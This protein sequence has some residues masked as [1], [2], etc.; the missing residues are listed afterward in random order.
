MSTV[1]AASRPRIPKDALYQT[2]AVAVGSVGLFV[3]ALAIWGG[4]LW[5]VLQG[6]IPPLLAIALQ[7]AASFMQFTVLHEGVHRSLLRGYPHLNDLMATCA[8][9]FLG[10]IGTCAAFRYVHF[11]H[12][13]HTNETD[14]DPDMWSGKGAAWRLP[15]QWATADIRYIV[16][17]LG[18]WSQLPVKDRVQIVAVTGSLFVGYIG[19]WFAGYGMEATLYW[20]VPSRLA[21]LWLAFAFN[22]LPHHPHDVLQSHNPYAAT[23]ARRGGE[24]WMKWLFLYQNYHIVHHLFPSVPFYR[25]QRIWA[26]RKAEFK[27]LGTPEVPW[28]RTEAGAVSDR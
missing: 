9:V 5:A 11:A 17:V 7:T 3:L 13:R 27:A 14:R 22:Y 23:N 20:L 19:C 4:A 25:Y 6:L 8:G 26:Q 16:I 12:H 28:Y 18:Q 24:P 21:I 10:A 15:L 1:A 2:P